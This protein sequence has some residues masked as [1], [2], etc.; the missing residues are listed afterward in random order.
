LLRDSTNTKLG[1]V[2]STNVNENLQSCLLDSEDESVTNVLSGSVMSPRGTILH[3]SNE[4]VAEEKRAQLEIFYTEP[5][6]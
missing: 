4:N 5:E 2:V 6:N 3:G 1:L